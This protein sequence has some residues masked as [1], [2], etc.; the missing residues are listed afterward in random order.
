MQS[1][2]L[3]WWQIFRDIIETLVTSV[4]TRIKLYN[5]DEQWAN[6]VLT[7]KSN[8]KISIPQKCTLRDPRIYFTLLI[9]QES[10]LISNFDNQLFVKS[11]IKKN[12]CCLQ[13]INCENLLSFFFL[14]SFFFFSWM[15][16]S[17]EVLLK[18]RWEFIF[19]WP[20]YELIYN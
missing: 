1:T 6:K 4:K 11:L 19:L 5:N 20:I 3:Y 17:S 10:R 7:K 9:I 12:S 8:I 13:L 15:S 16:N 18:L 2:H 14:H